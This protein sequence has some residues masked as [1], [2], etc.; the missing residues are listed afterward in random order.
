VVF[1]I[2]TAV[3]LI[4]LPAI[5]QKKTIQFDKELKLSAG[6]LFLNDILI[7]PSQEHN[8]CLQVGEKIPLNFKP[9]IIRH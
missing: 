4:S 2:Y 9:F 3:N 8:S 1:V 7:R 6:Q 5:I